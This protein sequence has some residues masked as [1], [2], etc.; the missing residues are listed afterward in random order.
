M[1]PSSVA[2]LDTYLVSL[3]WSKSENLGILEP[4]GQDCLF[5]MPRL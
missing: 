4:D 3:N 1:T 5:I 2:A